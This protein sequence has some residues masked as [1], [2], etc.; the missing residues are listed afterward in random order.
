MRP[1]D[2]SK[3]FLVNDI[4][5]RNMLQLYLISEMAMTG[6][7]VVP[8]L[9]MSETFLSRDRQPFVFFAGSI[10]GKRQE[11]VMSRA[12]NDTREIARSKYERE[13]AYVT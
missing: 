11:S 7:P 5:Y 1:P 2:S 8:A 6:M 10:K 3:P 13:P 9:L 12:M 4:S